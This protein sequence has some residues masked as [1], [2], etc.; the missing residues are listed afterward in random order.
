MEFRSIFGY[1]AGFIDQSK[2]ARCVEFAGH[3]ELVK[4]LAFLINRPL[5]AAEEI[6]PD[7]TL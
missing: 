6:F 3:E 1:D 5:W 2:I 7:L 4:D